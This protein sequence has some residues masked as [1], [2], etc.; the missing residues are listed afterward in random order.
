M[1]LI[2]VPHAA[3][4]EGQDGGAT[5]FV[6]LLE[7]ALRQSG[8][9]VTV[10]EGSVPRRILDLNRVDA[11]KSDF[12]MEVFDA[13]SE[14]SVHIDLH[15]Y[16]DISGE[17]EFGYDLDAW[18]ESTV[19]LFN[20]PEVTDETLLSAVVQAFEEGGVASTIQ[21]AGFENF[22]TNAASVLFDVPSVLIEVNDAAGR[23]YPV[24][25]DVLVEALARFLAGP[26]T[27]DTVQTPDEEAQ[28]P[29]Q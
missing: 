19:V 10:I 25:A 15:S 1:I 5:R 6:Y 4:G 12:M 27:P 7:D 23:D 29:A 20:I 26:E 18:R 14:A 17:T 28:S 21:E 8:E 11:A 9:L 3:P 2:T 13:L 24:V 22:L 16:P